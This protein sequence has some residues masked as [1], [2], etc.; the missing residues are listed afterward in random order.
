VESIRIRF[1]EIQN[2]L[3][4]LRFSR[5][6]F[7][8]SVQTSEEKS[9]SQKVERTYQVLKNNLYQV[10]NELEDLKMDLEGRSDYYDNK[11]KEF[12]KTTVSV[13]YVTLKD[14][15]L[16]AQKLYTDFK[17]VSKQKLAH[18]IKTLDM[19]DKLTLDEINKKAEEDPSA[20]S[21]MVQAKVMGNTSIKI[22]N[23]SV[24][25]SEKCESIRKLQKSVKELIEMMKEIS[26][27]IFQQGEKIKTIT[28]HVA[29]AI[30]HVRKVNTN[31]NFAKD[32]HSDS[33][34]VDL[35]ENVYHCNYRCLNACYFNWNFIFNLWLMF[36]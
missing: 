26:E 2:L 22:Q 6:Q 15:L 32:Y 25:I 10:K 18:Q 7:E 1:D 16:Q 13:F 21:K 31:L 17:D 4:D 20:L 33:R 35:L 23:A 30:D 12:V 19:D 11:E 28:D 3:E 24:D 29:T 8:N 5:S 27:I 9:I 34:C 36:K 14:R